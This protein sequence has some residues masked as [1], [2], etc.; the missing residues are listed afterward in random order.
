MVI[1]PRRQRVI[2]D[3]DEE[4]SD[5]EMEL[6]LPVLEST[7]PPIVEVMPI[8]P[9]RMNLPGFGEED[10]GGFSQF[11]A[12]DFSQNLGNVNNVLQSSCHRLNLLT[13]LNSGGRISKACCDNGKRIK[14]Y[15]SNSD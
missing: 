5:N 11:F 1:V 12:D 14:F 2:V 13:N 8:L 9:A 15:C 10:E 7:T 6:D 3:D 4:D